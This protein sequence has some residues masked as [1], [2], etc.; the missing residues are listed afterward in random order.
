MTNTA[1]A[2]A[3][4]VRVEDGGLLGGVCNDTAIDAL[5]C[6]TIAIA[7]TELGVERR[8]ELARGICRT[9]SKPL[10]QLAQVPLL[11]LVHA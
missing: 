10:C 6:A 8:P 2:D 7:G 4:E 1:A 3:G 5:D 11:G 9:L